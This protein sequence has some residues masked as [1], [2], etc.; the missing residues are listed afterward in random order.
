MAMDKLIRDFLEH[1][2]Y[3]LNYSEL[4]VKN[5]SVDLEQ[6]KQYLKKN[7]PD[8]LANLSL[9][10]NLVIRGFLAELARNDIGNRSRGRKL[11]TL[12]SFFR[13]LKRE[14][15]TNSNPASI[16]ATPRTDKKL[17]S[18]FTESEMDQFL[19]LP[20]RKS[21]AGLRDSAVLELLYSTG[22]RSSEL[23]SLRIVDA[24][25]KSG[26][27]RV[28]GKGSKER[29]VP[30]GDPAKDKLHDYLIRRNELVRRSKKGAQESN[31]YVFLSV[32]GTQLSTRSLRRIVNK[33]IRLASLHSRLSAHSLRH[34]FA[35]HLLNA[36]ADL[37]SIQELLGHASLSTTQKYTQ[38]GLE[39]LIETYKKTHP[40]A[41]KDKIKNSI[42]DENDYDKIIEDKQD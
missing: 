31:D 27:V 35:T 14:G 40:H 37:R 13:W 12:R 30:F 7:S 24:D 21:I 20:D 1:L 26:F 15:Y 38:V 19:D 16:V 8:G 18:F 28:M 33:Y 39:K 22:I 34:S 10:D 11:A 32:R 3:R 29:M 4:T 2:K 42:K 5:Y 23:V 6:F 25:L 17:P 9:I 41:T 36:G